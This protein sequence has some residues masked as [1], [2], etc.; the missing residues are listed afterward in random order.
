MIAEF[1]PLQ[2]TNLSF[3]LYGFAIKSHTKQ[4]VEFVLSTTTTKKKKIKISSLRFDDEEKKWTEANQFKVYRKVFFF[5]SQN[6][7]ANATNQK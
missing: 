5:L 7:N 3:S 6:A 2:H 1:Y 4:Q